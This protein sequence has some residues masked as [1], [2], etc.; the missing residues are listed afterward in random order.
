[1]N[2]IKLLILILLTHSCEVLDEAPDIYYQGYC[3]CVFWD[4]DKQEMV[5]ILMRP[6]TY[7]IGLGELSRTE[8]CEDVMKGDLLNCKSDL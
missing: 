3:D 1:M 6:G 4:M 2:K 7:D 5:K 8:Y